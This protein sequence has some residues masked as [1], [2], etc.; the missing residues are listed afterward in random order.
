MK[1]ERLGAQG[2]FREMKNLFEEATM[3]AVIDKASPQ[4][5]AGPSVLHYYHLQAAVCNGLVED[6]AAFATLVFSSRGLPK[7]F[8]HCTRALNV[9]V[10]EK[11]GASGVRLRLRGSYWRRF[12]R[13]YDKKLADYSQPWGQ[14]GVAV[15]G[16]VEIMGLTA[17][18]GFEE[19]CTIL[20]YDGGNASTTYTASG[21]CER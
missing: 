5:A 4:S 16:R 13:R 12:Y 10:E 20:S 14:Y 6:L 1:T 19:G 3:K 7:D 11:D 8:R 21:S 15:S 18:L 9:C 2:Q 17:T